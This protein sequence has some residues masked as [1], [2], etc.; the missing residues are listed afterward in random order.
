MNKIENKLIEIFCDIDDFNQAF[1][2]ELQTHQLSDGTRKRIKPS[3]LSESEVMTIVTY[4]HIIRYRDFKHYYLFHVCKNMREEFPQLVS[5]NRFVELMQSAMLPL[6]VFIKTQR[7]GRCTGISFIDSTLLRD[8]QQRASAALGGSSDLSFI[9]SSMTR[10]ISL[11][12]CLLPAMLKTESPFPELTCSRGSTASCS[13]I[14]DTF[15]RLFSSSFLLTGS[16]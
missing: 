15:P 12:L 5:Y 16:I 6:I 4:F 14:R 10:E 7:L 11:I 9:S 1:I 2:K 8:L 3:K 13:V